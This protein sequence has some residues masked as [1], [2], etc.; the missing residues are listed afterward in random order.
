MAEKVK[1]PLVFSWEGVD[2]K[3]GKIKGESRAASVA[4]VKA[5]LRKQGIKPGKV[6]KKAQPL[7]SSAKK[8]TP[9][10]IAVF[11]RQLSTMMRAGVPLVQ[12]FDIVG[13]GHENPSMQELLMTIKKDV[14]G[15]AT[16][17]NA[18]RDHPKYF[19]ELYCNLVDAG[20]QGGILE[21]LLD[22]VATYKESVESIKGK[23]KKAMFY[24]ASVMIVAVIVTAVIMIFVVPQF[25]EL[26]K[27][28]GADL[29]A[30]TQIVINISKFLTTNGL[31][32]LLGLVGFIWGVVK[33]IKSSIKIQRGLDR[34]LLRMPI[35]GGIL[36]NAAIARYCRT[37]STMFA[38]GVP[39]VDA[40][41]SVAGAA[42]N[43]VYT[44]AIMNIRD[45]VATGQSLQLSMKQQNIFPNMVVQMVAIGEESGAHG[46]HAG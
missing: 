7:F 17:A 13:Q 30:L 38:A 6:R 14:E 33:L 18:L 32:V 41:T 29:P 8:I 34:M 11:S 46:F 9:G 21:T 19:D 45:E 2:R 5:E 25:E 42:G 15:G 39:L 35:V 37:L 1:K 31:W 28:F 3:G 10:D 40:L 16:L 24:P 22:K 27:G 20:E 4:L 43:V 44:E 23:I 36:N 12:S 26:F